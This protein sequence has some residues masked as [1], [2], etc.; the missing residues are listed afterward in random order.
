MPKLVALLKENDFNIALSEVS[1]RNSQL[2]MVK[3]SLNS[4]IMI[5]FELVETLD[6]LESL[7]QSNIPIVIL[8]HADWHHDSNIAKIELEKTFKYFNNIKQE[9]NDNDNTK[10][11]I[12]YILVDMN[13]N[14][15]EE[16]AIELNIREPGMMF[17]Y[18][19][20]HK[21]LEV[22]KSLLVSSNDQYAYASA[23]LTMSQI[24]ENNDNDNDDAV[25]TKNKISTLYEKNLKNLNPKLLSYLKENDD[26]NDEINNLK[27]L[28]IIKNNLLSVKHN[29]VK[30]E[31]K[32]N[33]VS[34]DI[35]QHVVPVTILSGFLGSGKV[36]K[37]KFILYSFFY[38]NVI[39]F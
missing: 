10:T 31:M 16:I 17:C 21:V 35:K 39:F 37:Y 12:K 23:C 14:E 25:L 22:N 28:P 2:K 15:G 19:K 8:F 26:E 6:D 5:K 24:I 33:E 38:Y 29:D 7:I 20:H 34:I 27:T 32:S 1:Q 36:R 9:S 30:I 13:E 4:S 11:E 18:F 3:P